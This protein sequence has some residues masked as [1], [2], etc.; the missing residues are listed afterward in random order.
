MGAARRVTWVLLVAIVSGCGGGHANTSGSASATTTVPEHATVPESTTVAQGPASAQLTF[1]G[2][3]GLGGVVTFTDVKCD[4]PQADGSE[5]LFLLASTPGSTL[6]QFN[7]HISSDQIDVLVASGSGQNFTSREFVGSGV[8]GFDAAKGAMIDTPVAETTSAS[9]K[10]GT[11]GAISG[12]RGSINCG[13]QSPG[14]S[15]VTYTGSATEGAVNGPAQPF[16]VE[17]SS[18]SVFFVGVVKV[19]SQPVMFLTTITASSVNSFVAG[20]G[21]SH[22]YRAQAAGVA[23]VSATGAHVVADMVEQSPASGHP[24]AIHIEGDLTCGQQ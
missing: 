23:T 2:D 3:A 13:H 17:C 4:E 15:T 22:T 10:R 19:G 20:T 21:I 5:I 6:V 12:V 16:R 1:A 18:G 11:I 7:I 24:H 9:A 14:S 8:T